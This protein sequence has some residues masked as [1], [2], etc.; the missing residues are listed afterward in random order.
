MDVE[1]G[2]HAHK[3]EVVPGICKRIR[4]RQIENEEKWNS[5]DKRHRG[6]PASAIGP[7]GKIFHSSSQSRRNREVGRVLV[8]EFLPG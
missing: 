8:L 7:V 4:G 5:C 2:G 6:E 1:C 3:I